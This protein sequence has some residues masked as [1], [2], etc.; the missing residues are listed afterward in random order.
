M[1]PSRR[2]LIRVLIR[3]V[4]GGRPVITIFFIIVIQ[5]TLGGSIWKLAL[6]PN[7]KE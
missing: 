5:L 2:V 7:S 3:R 4:P 6:K 1:V